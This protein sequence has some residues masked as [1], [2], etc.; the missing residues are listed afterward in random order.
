MKKLIPFDQLK[1]QKHSG[2]D[3]AIACTFP[4]AT[5]VVKDGIIGIGFGTVTIDGIAWDWILKADH[6]LFI[7]AE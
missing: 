2:L 6:Y 4:G 7:E 3:G 1:E 5:E